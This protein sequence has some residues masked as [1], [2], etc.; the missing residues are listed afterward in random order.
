MYGSAEDP[1]SPTQS[2]CS[3]T[4]DQIHFNTTSV[5]GSAIEAIPFNIVEV[6]AENEENS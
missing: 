1:G 3:S 5:M 6:E 2:L 4:V